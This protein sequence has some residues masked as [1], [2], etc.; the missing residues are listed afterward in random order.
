MVKKHLNLIPGIPL[1]EEENQL[2]K[3]SSALHMHAVA[4][5]YKYT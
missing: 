4:H 5:M 1:V 2:L 3:L